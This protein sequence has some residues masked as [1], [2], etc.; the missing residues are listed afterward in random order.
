MYEAVLGHCLEVVQDNYQLALY[1]LEAFKRWLAFM[2]SVPQINDKVRQTFTNV[3]S[4]IRPQQ[5]LDFWPL[6]LANES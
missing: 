3:I 5:V 2:R 4:R 1:D 6:L